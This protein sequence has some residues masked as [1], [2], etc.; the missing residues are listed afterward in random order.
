MVKYIVI[1]RNQSNARG[2]TVRYGSKVLERIDITS[3]IA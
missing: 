1:A 3:K 2:H